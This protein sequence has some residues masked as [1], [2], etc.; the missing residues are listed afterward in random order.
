VVIDLY[1]R[2]VVGWAMSDSPDAN[3]VVRA[4]DQ[5]YESRGRPSDVM[6]HSDQGSQY[7]S[8]MF[9]QRLWRYR[10]TQSMSR[11]GNCW[12][13]AP[14]ERL[15]RSLK[16]EWIP[17]MGYRTREEAERDIGQYLMTYFNWQ[18]PHRYNGGLPPGK[19]E[20]LLKTMS[21]NS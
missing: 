10:F 7:G 1:V 11:R 8:R 4:L 18:R 20:K 13:N 15:F 14:M 12:D 17:P 6:F 21:G 19:A 5:A 2:K 9:R 16:T 3:L